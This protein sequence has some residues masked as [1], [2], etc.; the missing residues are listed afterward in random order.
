MKLPGIVEKRK[1]STT[2]RPRVGFFGLLGSGNLG[3]D[4]SFEVL[5]TYLRNNH[6]DAVIDAMCMGPDKLRAD[7]G[8]D[9]IPIEW[10]RK[11]RD[12]TSGVTGLALNVMG[13]G[14]DAFRTLSWVRQ[15]DV[16]IV[17]GMGIIEP[18]LPLRASGV[19]YAL[20]LL[21][22]SGKLVGT[23][24]ALVCVGAGSTNRK[25]TRLLLT[26]AARL[27][28]YRSY[29]DA[30]SRDVVQRAGIDTSQDHV[31]PDLVFALD[32]PPSEAG[33][34]AVVSVGVMDY[35]GG[36]DDRAQAQDIH[37]RYIQALQQFT[38][39]LLGTNH[40]VRIRWGDDVDATVAR[41]LQAYLRAG[42]PDLGPEFVTLDPC[43]SLT[44][45]I[46]RLAPAGTVV[47]TRFHGVLSALKLAKPTIALAYSHKHEALIADMGVPE[48]SLSARAL[49]GDAL[50]KSFTELEQRSDELRCT[51]K[52]RNV[53]Q[54]RRLEEQFAV[55]SS[56]IGSENLRVPVLT[57]SPAMSGN[58]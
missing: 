22:A 8:I 9:A 12:R 55:L 6:S 25:L 24:V 21:C 38:L 15:H 7:Y 40:R 36:N 45:L 18:S 19:P 56:L 28:Y 41:E 27:A 37:R 42:R 33:D 43:S 39:W 57:E 5:L 3:N 49:D 30:Q 52:E 46:G 31:Y 26:G 4:A 14:I 11:Y 48:F 32:T 54:R 13:K 20:F 35:N 58:A 44:E 2:V 17:P 50:I 16:V 29:R 51:L 10:Y 1:A 47:A 53:V 34:P 23:K